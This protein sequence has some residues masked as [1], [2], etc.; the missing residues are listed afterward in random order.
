MKIAII[1]TRGIPACYGGFE[2]F[3]EE[4]SQRLVLRGHEVTVYGRSNIIRYPHRSYKGVG[5]VILPTISHKYLD[6][7]VHTFI[8]IVHCVFQDFEVILLCNAANAIF[9][10]IPRL[11][12]KKVFI[13]VDGIERKRAKWNNLG[14]IWYRLGEVCATVFPNAFI[15]DATEIQKYF[16]KT[17]SK[18]SVVIPY[19]AYTDIVSSTAALD[20][21]G[22]KKRDYVLYVTRLEPENNV[23]ML[24]NAFERIKTDKKLVIV[25]DAPYSK[26]YI[27]KLKSTKDPRIIFTGYVF[28]Q[29]YRE[30]ISHAYCCVNATSVGGTHPALIEALGAGNCVIVN[31]TPENREVVADA[32]VVFDENSETDLKAKL[33]M[34][35]NG[36]I[37]I[38]DYRQRA[39]ARVEA[40]YT[41]DR[42]TDSYE[43]LFTGS[44][45]KYKR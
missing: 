4:L 44:V 20:A 15:S 21:F 30:F 1:G 12:G 13:N 43:Q 3:A 14:K 2:T 23:H 18:D 37:P 33:E 16:Q 27:A 17:Y 28:G 38:E 31:G 26:D 45:P 29:G 42:V 10:F 5:L 36:E 25:G 40:C 7:V 32:A 39:R 22:L 41:W 24:I 8:S 6:T 9:S 34:A 19:G 11:A 35:I